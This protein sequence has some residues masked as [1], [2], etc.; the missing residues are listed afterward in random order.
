MDKAQAKKR[1]EE[2]REVINEHN[3]NYYVKDQPTISDQEYDRLLR[4]LIELE[5]KFPEFLTPDSP[6]QK[7]GGE[8][9]PYFEKV[10]H[11]VPMLSLGNAFDEG[12]LRDFDRRVRQG[13]GAERVRY[14]CELKIDGLAVSL[15]YEDG[16]FVRGATRGDG[17]TGEDITQNLK[18]IRSLPLRLKKPLTLEV[19]GEAFMPKKAFER[20]NEERAKKGE[21]LFANPRN[22]AAGSLRQLDPK[23][24]AERSLDLFVYGIGMLEGVTLESHSEGLALLEELGF[25]VNPER[26]VFDA[27]EEVIAF[28]QGWAAKRATLPYEIDGMVIKVDS[29][30]LQQKLGFTAKSPRW[31][32]AYKFPAEEAVTILEDIEVNVGRTGAVTPTAILAPV[33]LAGTTV[34]R[35]SL[36]NEDI[37]REKGLMIGDHVIVRK[38]G[39]IIPEVVGVLAEKRTGKERPFAMPT[40]CPECHSELVRLAG[41]VALR[42]VNPKCPAHIREG[43]IH[44]ASRDAMNIEGLGEKVVTQLFAHGLVKSFADLYELKREELLQLERMGEKSVDNLLAAIEASKKNSVERLIFGLGIRFVGAKAAKVLAQ[45]FGTLD[46]LVEATEEE[47]L[48]IG[49]IGPKMAES[50]RAYFDNP[51][52][53]ETLARLKRNGVN[54]AYKGPRPQGA[55]ADSPFA[56]KTVVLTGT[57]ESMSRKEAAERIEALGGKVAGSVSKNTDLVIA[58]EKAGSKLDKAQQLGIP[59]LDEAAFLQMLGERENGNA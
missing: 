29:L 26:R 32:I 57:L 25:K 38:A 37:I 31:A 52:V 48:R 33:S 23:I 22:A 42:C 1:I 24:A 11:P 49:E 53:R 21:P 54:F 59:V 55:K 10:V 19:R 39:D 3:Y 2:L 47:L 15:R 14:V 16:L 50:I 5:E 34:R 7:V 43:L 8:P 30:A 13:T 4:E 17:T 27:I 41:E 12:E 6:S 28:V 44:F 58:G 20:L 9:L 56:G 35:A 45:E 46:R 40:H 51:D 36:H 18:T